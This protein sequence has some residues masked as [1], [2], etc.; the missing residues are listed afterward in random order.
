MS[1]EFR[2]L[3]EVEA[4]VEGQP[5]DIGHARQRCVLACLLVDVNRPV[6]PAQL[7][8]R[9]W[10][11]DPPHRARNALAAYISRLRQ[12]LPDDVAIVRGPGGYTLSAVAGSID[13]HIFRDLVA[14][15][16]RADRSSDAATL[17]ERALSLWGGVPFASLETPWAD[18]MR[19][20]LE[21]ERFAVQLDRN[22]AAI[23]AGRH[24]GLLA[25]L[26][27][28]LQANPLDERVAGQMMLAQ[29]RSGRQADALET[30]RTVRNRLVEE[31]GVDPGPG[32]R[33]MHEHILDGEAA[34]EPVAADPATVPESA[35]AQGRRTPP[36][37][38]RRV[39]SLVGR[40]RELD[41]V[42]RALAAAPLVTLTGVGGVGKTTLAFEAAHRLQGAFPDGVW[43]VE[44]APVD[45]A[46]AV[47]HA[48]AATL[49]LR[50]R[51]GI[52]IDEAVIDH[53]RGR[54]LLLVMD[55]CEHLLD[56]AARLVDRITRHCP[57]AAV[58]ATSREP[59]GIEGERLLPVDPLPTHEAARLFADRAKSIRPDFDLDREPVGAVAEICRR[60]DGVPLAIELAAARMRVMG[61]LDV[62]RRLD[63]LRLLRGGSRGAHPRQQSVAA[64][65]DWSYRL[66]DEAEQTLFARL[67]IFAGSFD[68]DAVHAV[69]TEDGATEDDTLD[70]LTGLVDKSMVTVRGGLGGVTRYGVLETLRTYGRELLYHSGIEDKIASR[71][72]RYYIELIQRA[73]RGMR[74][75][76][77]PAWVRRMVPN[78][79]S[80][81]TAPDYDNVRTAFERVLAE[82]DIDLALCL[83]TSLLE[84]MNRIGYHSSVW[85]DRVVGLA[86]PDHPLFPA[87]VGVAA[88]AAWVLDDMPRARSLAALAR[89]RPP[90]PGAS[91][92]GYPGDVLADAA[93]YEGGAASTLAHYENEAVGARGGNDAHRLTWILYNI[94]ISHAALHQREAGLPVAQEALKVAETTA[95]PTARSMARCALGRALA[96]AD[97]DRALTVLH[98]AVELAGS[99]E[100]NWL[101]GV[102][103]TESAAIRAAHGDP[104]AAARVLIDTLDHWCHGGPGMLPQQWDTLRSAARFLVRLGADEEAVALHRAVVAAGHEPPLSDAQLVGRPPIKGVVLSGPEAVHLARTMLGRYG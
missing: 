80:T 65:I 85:V 10:A 71:H 24:G 23:D 88:R 50:P 55:N 21:A 95:N 75:V 26:A 19:T 33:R 102:A 27:R 103:W 74:G 6:S 61:S 16:R 69:C 47:G 44:L 41:E 32:L 83:V 2:L 100:N 30:Y 54:R 34:A 14:T 91:Y 37:L 38:P 40:E 93:L 28:T 57:Q 79:R 73:E 52:G 86:D 46:A 49:W 3:G 99:V 5:L 17:F 22:D 90:P 7:I 82:G 87:A 77:E 59:L 63:R 4:L 48:V 81:F 89:E 29:Y 72:A 35:P 60:L 76:D 39:A 101:V 67:S 56:G 18:D 64:T 70:L 62:A 92:L 51:A 45:D 98:E 97:P 8:D 15:A 25:E 68:L 20:A 66:L 13:L 104:T 36:A 96:E 42:A 53:L 12:V 78:A 1:V 43:I 11:D 94:T 84:V 31:L 9:V 58:L